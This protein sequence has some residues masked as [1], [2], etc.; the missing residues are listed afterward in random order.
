MD[1]VVKELQRIAKKHRGLL[2]PATVVEYAEDPKSPLHDY[3]DWDDTE[4]A[5]KWRLHQARNLIRVCIE[6]R[7]VGEEPREFKVFVSLRQDR[8]NGFGYRRLTD[9]LSDAELTLQL[10]HDCHADYRTFYEKYK[11]LKQ[12]SEVLART[13]DAI[14]DAIAT[15]ATTT[16]LVQAGHSR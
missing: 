13:E 12:L 1:E 4:A 10:L 8:S 7:Q 14:L 16:A 2:Q 11:S 15:S 3:F 9:V 6:Y 5:R